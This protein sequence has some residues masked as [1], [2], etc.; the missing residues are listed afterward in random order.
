MG[1]KTFILTDHRETLKATDTT[2]DAV[3][4]NEYFLNICLTDVFEGQ[5]DKKTEALP[6]IALLLPRPKMPKRP[7]I[8]QIKDKKWNFNLGLLCEEQGPKDLAV[9]SCL[10]GYAIAA[11]WEEKKAKSQA[12]AL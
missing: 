10:A 3:H 4:W 2:P 9:T 8:G 1:T 11:S 7:G 5:T 12:Q 6:F